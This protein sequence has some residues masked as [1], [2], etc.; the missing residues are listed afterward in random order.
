[1]LFG[2]LKSKEDKRKDKISKSLKGFY[3]KH[4]YSRGIT[5]NNGGVKQKVYI[6]R[7]NEKFVGVSDLG[8]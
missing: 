2:L 3:D 1:M 7:K 8:K 4:G 6:K 5:V